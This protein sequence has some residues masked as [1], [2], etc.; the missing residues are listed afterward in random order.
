MTQT[1]QNKHFDLHT[2][3]FGFFNRIRE[4]KPA[5]GK[6]YWAVTVAACRGD[7]GQKTYFECSVVGSAAKA[8]FDEHLSSVSKDDTITASFKLGDL[9]PETFVYG[10]GKKQGQTGVILRARLL[11][12]TYLKVNDKVLVHSQQQA[13]SAPA[14][15]PAQA[16]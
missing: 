8:L 2:S 1:T 13:E 7:E 12:I 5:K 14:Q 11:K 15:T 10:P 16:A 3:G 4:I 6:P 9:Y